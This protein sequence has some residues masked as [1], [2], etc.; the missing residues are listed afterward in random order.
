MLSLVQQAPLY[1][2]TQ[3]TLYQVRKLLAQNFLGLRPSKIMLYE[4]FSLYNLI[5]DSNE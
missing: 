2:Q 5:Q 1:L 3:A 4:E